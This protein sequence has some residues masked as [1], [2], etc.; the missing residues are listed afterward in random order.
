MKRLDEVG[1]K[2]RRLPWAACLYPQSS[3]VAALLTTVMV[4]GIGH[5]K[6][7][8]SWQWNTHDEI[9]ILIRRGM[10]IPFSLP[11]RGVGGYSKKA[12]AHEPGK[13]LSQHIQSWNSPP[14]ECE[15]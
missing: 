1:T 10:R 13:V 2:Q 11:W 4:F 15:K 9:N 14:P 3:Y 7:I 6:I 12:V 8:K 5:W